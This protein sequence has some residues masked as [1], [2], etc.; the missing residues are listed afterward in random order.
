MHPMGS[1]ARPPDVGLGLA[2]PHRKQL[3][4]LDADEVGLALVGDGLGQQRLPTAWQ[5][6]RYERRVGTKMTHRRCGCQQESVR[7]MNVTK[8]LA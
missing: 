4:A 7:R 8:I 5:T 3:G 6:G 2:E 1:A